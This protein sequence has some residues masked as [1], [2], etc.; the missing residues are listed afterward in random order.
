ML[1]QDQTLIGQPVISDGPADAADPT[2][3]N[4]PARDGGGA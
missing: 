2:P 4:R 1:A 3:A